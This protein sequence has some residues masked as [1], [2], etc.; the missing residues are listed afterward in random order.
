[1]SAIRVNIFTNNSC[2]NSQAFNCPLLV[3]QNIF[4]NRGV[5]LQFHYRSTHKLFDADCI[6]I[7]SNVFRPWWPTRKN[8]IFEFLHSARKK[9]L[10]IFWF[11]TT[12]STWCTQF[13]VLHYVDLF[14]KSQVFSNRKN[15]LKRYRTGRIFTDYLDEL[16]GSGEREKDYELPNETELS[17]LRVSWNTCFENYTEKRYGMG[18]RLRQRLRGLFNSPEHF[19]ITFTKP[20][21]KRKHSISCRLGIMHTSPTVVAHRQA[22]MAEIEK[23]GKSC[24][25]I[26]MHKYFDELRNSR[27]VISPFG[28]GEICYRDFETIIAGAT[29]LKPDCDH[30][31]TWPELFQ[32]GRTYVPHR[33][34]LSDFNE[35]IAKLLKEQERAIEIAI[36]AQR[37]YKRAL[38][39]EG[40]EIFV[41]RVIKY[42]E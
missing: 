7:N 1:M 39:E 19:K 5:E 15:Y 41:E 13:A 28:W 16:Y 37:V 10:K 21:K 40:Q 42:L 8:E 17:K 18:E 32:P 31:E 3:T 25:K 6:F 12:D 11:D 34:D 14:L 22:I 36:T 38:S 23:M 30:M 2:P 20:E 27:V 29:L 9:G 26:P 35:V 24:G 4:R 33:W